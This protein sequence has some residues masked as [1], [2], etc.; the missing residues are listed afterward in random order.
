MER[1]RRTIGDERGAIFVQVGI[2]VLALMAFN[3]FVLDYGMLWIARGQA[4]NAADAGALA[5]ALARGYDDRNN[6]PAPGGLAADIATAVAARTQVWTQAPSATASFACPNGVNGRCT[7]V[8]VYRDGTNGSTALPTLFGPIIGINSQ[9][10]RATAT[11]VTANGNVTPCMRPFA[12][13]DLWIEDAPDDNEFNHYRPGTQQLLPPADR[14]EYTPPSSTQPGLTR[15]STNYGER[16]VWDLVGWGAIEA[17]API[18]R[19]LVVPLDLPGGETYQQN[20]V[21]CV[22]QPLRLNDTVPLDITITPAI[23]AAA[24]TAVF[25]QDR[26]ADYDYGNS[27]IVNSCA[28]ACAPVSP[29]LIPIALYDP[30]RFQTGLATDN[31]IAAGCPTNN[32]CVTISNI[33][34][35]FVHRVGATGGFGPHGH[36]LRYP[37]A[38]ATGAPTFVDDA[39]WLVTTYLIR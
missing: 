10:V 5:G 2:A 12:F 9:S 13:A 20:M 26:N 37:G 34:G 7:R 8:D 4:Q 30:L 25:N 18:T 32:P 28:P 16:I 1:V 11:A 21:Q 15:I 17:G 31:W 14:D 35:F 19:N 29:R 27:R 39:S 3:V 22:G 23:E 6:P 36:V 24:F 33:V 38:A